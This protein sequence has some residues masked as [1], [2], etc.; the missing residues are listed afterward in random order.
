MRPRTRE[1]DIQMIAP[2]LGQGFST[3][4]IVLADELSIELF[5]GKLG[6][7]GHSKMLRP[8]AKSLVF[9]APLFRFALVALVVTVAIL[10]VVGLT[11]QIRQPDFQFQTE[12]AG[13]GRSRVIFVQPTS[14]VEQAGL[15]VGDVIDRT[16]I[17]TAEYFAQRNP[18][19]G[20]RETLSVDRGGERRSVSFV[21]NVRAANPIER[22]WLGLTLVVIAL[23]TG[24]LVGLRRADRPEGRLLSLLL[25]DMALITAAGWMYL[26]AATPISAW[27]W[28]AVDAYIAFAFINY[29][30]I[31]LATSFPAVPTRLRTFLRRTALPIALLS[32]LIY[33]WYDA[34]HFTPVDPLMNV[35]INHI[36]LAYFALMLVS[37][38]GVALIC[39]VA[40]LDGL[41]HVDVDRRAQMNWVTAAIIANQVP[42]LFLALAQI[43]APAWQ[44]PVFS[45]VQN[46][47]LPNIP[48]LVI[49]PYVILRH[50]LLDLSIVVSRTAIFASVSLIVVSAFIVGEWVIG[51][52]A[53]RFVPGTGRDVAGQGLLLVLALAIGLS[54]QK[55]HSV[56][57]RRL[58]GVFFAKRARSLANLRRFS[59]ETDVVVKGPALLKLFYEAVI[60]NTEATYA[61]MYLRDGGT[62]VLTHASK[63]DVPQG[64]DEDDPAVVKLRRWNE[65]Y[66][67]ERSSHAFSEALI[68]PMTVHGMLFG[69]L[70]C[71]PKKERTHFAGE[72]VDVLA[73]AAHRTGIAHLFLSNESLSGRPLVAPI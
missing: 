17:P 40:C 52:V 10:A 38:V 44:I 15:A 43:I 30:L 29:A 64:I 60:A 57:D 9:M 31:V 24:L 5:V 47:D 51:N 56:V 61:A 68:I 39:I 46:L 35:S 45:V 50:R 63:S 62:F 73:H 55:I 54:A 1:R 59:Q 8:D 7:Y 34:Q 23:G 16:H 69:I 25:V 67:Y 36:S 58:N 53:Q 22:G 13:V 19:V 70:V 42:W 26:V 18:R 11:G 72:E 33:A 3:K 14:S 4:C 20:Q 37:N 32:D 71:G 12:P 65:P 41:A 66:E 27:A 6:L 28:T 49:L 48:L 2:G 21:M